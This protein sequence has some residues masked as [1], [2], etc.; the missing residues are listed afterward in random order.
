MKMLL[1]DFVQALQHPANAIEAKGDL[2]L[3]R[4]HIR[5]GVA[6]G[7]GKSVLHSAPASLPDC[8]IPLGVFKDVKKVCNDHPYDSVDITDNMLKIKYLHLQ[9]TDIHAY[10]S[11]EI[12]YPDYPNPE[13]VFSVCAEHPGVFVDLETSRSFIRRL[14]SSGVIS[15]SV[16]QD[17]MYCNDVPAL[18]LESRPINNLRIVVAIDIKRNDSLEPFGF[19]VPAK[20]LKKAIKDFRCH[21]VAIH[22]SINSGPVML[23]YGYVR[24]VIM[25]FRGE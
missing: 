4:I 14:P 10:H 3:A 25:P 9:T 19:K 1:K 11:L 6:Y 12:T 13:D 24:A 22:P 5:N 20:M 15:F 18:V 21:W 2:D 23:K 8:D 17:S 16:S 7:A